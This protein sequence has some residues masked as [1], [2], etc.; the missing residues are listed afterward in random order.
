MTT[1]GASIDKIS[2]LLDVLDKHIEEE[3]CSHTSKE[4][5]K[6]YEN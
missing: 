5:L 4:H 2:R 6:E 3:N 1:N